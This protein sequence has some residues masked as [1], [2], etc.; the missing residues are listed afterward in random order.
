[1]AMMEAEFSKYGALKPPSQPPFRGPIMIYSLGKDSK[2]RS[3]LD[4][5]HGVM[6][7]HV[8]SGNTGI[9]H[10]RQLLWQMDSS[11]SSSSAG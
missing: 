3:W 1:M 6:M 8:A 4:V 10:L 7:S 9:A 2:V 11:G 5:S